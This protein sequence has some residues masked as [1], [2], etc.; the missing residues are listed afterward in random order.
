MKKPLPPP[1]AASPGTT[2]INSPPPAGGNDEP[3]ERGRS[4]QL[5]IGLGKEVEEGSVTDFTTFFSF[6]EHLST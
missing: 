2:T 5:R 3:R 1:P 6:S 4:N